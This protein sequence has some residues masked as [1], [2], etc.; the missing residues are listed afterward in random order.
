MAIVCGA[1]ERW[2]V[3]DG[4][5][6]GPGFDLSVPSNTDPDLVY[7]LVR[8]EVTGSVIHSPACK[9]W[10]FGHRRCS[11]LKAA[12]ARAEQPAAAFM[13]AVEFALST[14]TWWA[15]PAEAEALCGSI[16]RLLD[17]AKAQV[18]RNAEG[19]KAREASDAFNALPAE[20]QMAAAVDT[21]GSR[22]GGRS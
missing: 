11:H 9:A 3:V 2:E 22:A 16:R 6:V 21:F 20:A 18:S 5:P 19:A 7:H 15:S 14:S 8:D 1:E 12:I 10:L 4:A 17:E 13:G